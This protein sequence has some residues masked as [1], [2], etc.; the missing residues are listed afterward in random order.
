MSFA[1]VYAVEQDLFNDALPLSAKTDR[2]GAFAFR[3]GVPLGT[4]KLYS[5]KYAEGYPD[6]LD[7]VYADAK[8]EAPKVELTENPSPRNLN[9]QARSKSCN[10]GWKG[11]RRQCRG[12][13]T[14]ALAFHGWR[15][16]WTFRTGNG[17]I[18][19]SCRRAKT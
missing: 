18:A 7:N 16:T 19:S 17:S 11:C 2:N 10:R 8:A 9:L 3:D 12:S 14:R 15:R 5:A 4:Y 1:T 13:L 6:P